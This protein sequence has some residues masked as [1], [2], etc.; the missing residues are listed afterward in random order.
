M[1]LSVYNAVLL[2]GKG[3]NFA[4]SSFEIVYSSPNVLWLEKKDNQT[5]YC[6]NLQLIRI[7]A[8]KSE[9]AKVVT[10][11]CRWTQLK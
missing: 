11:S 4:A 8:T 10:N 3:I 2:T 9:K 1:L 6:S 5:N 7:I